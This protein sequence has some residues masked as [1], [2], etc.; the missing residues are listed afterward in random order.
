MTIYPPAGASIVLSVGGV[1][2]SLAKA[3]I[4]IVGVNLDSGVVLLQYGQQGIWKQVATTIPATPMPAGATL[5]PVLQAAAHQTV[6][7][8]QIAEESA[9]ITTG[10]TT[11]SVP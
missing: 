9:G 5:L 2:V 10:S 11:V 8:D 1:A 3:I 4:Q 6:E 7:A